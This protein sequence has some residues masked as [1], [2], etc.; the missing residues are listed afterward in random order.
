MCWN[1][2]ISLLSFVFIVVSC[3]VLINYETDD[4]TTKQNKIIGYY[5]LFVGLM[6]LIDYLIWI[7]LKCN[8]RTNKLAGYLGPLL[9]YLQPVVLLILLLYNYVH[10]YYYL[11]ILQWYENYKL[12]QRMSF[13]CSPTT[14]SVHKVPP[15]ERVCPCVRVHVDV[16]V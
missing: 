13:T 14:Q 2:E 16:Y 11:I 10:T 5:L 1:K 6:Q 3:I 15:T 4:I 8:K 7:D 9:N 12:L